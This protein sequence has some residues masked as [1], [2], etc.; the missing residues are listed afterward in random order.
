MVKA[1]LT[2]SQLLVSELFTLLGICTGTSPLP[3]LPPPP[4]LFRPPL[5]CDGTLGTVHGSLRQ[6]QVTSTWLV[7][8]DALRPSMVGIRRSVVADGLQPCTMRLPPPLSPA[9]PPSLSSPPPLSPF[10]SFSRSLHMSLFVALSLH[11][12]F[13]FMSLI[14]AACVLSLP[15]KATVC[16]S[17]VH[18]G[19]KFLNLL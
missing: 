14:R 3:S 11:S 7:K 9:F 5:A 1:Q 18:G 16:V 2:I 13:L 17:R 12:L 6:V 15:L 4:H 8:P 19:S 10:L